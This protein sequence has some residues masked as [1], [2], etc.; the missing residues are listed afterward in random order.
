[1]TH[2]ERARTEDHPSAQPANRDVAAALLCAVVG[3]VLAVEPHLAILARHG[4][5]ADFGD[6]DDVLYTTLA[7]GPYRS[8]WA[9]GDPF[10]PAWAPQPTL[11]SWLPFVPLAKLTAVLGIDRL[12]MP[13]VWRALGGPMLGLAV[14]IVFRRLL[15][16]TRRPVSWALGCA[17]VSLA[18]SGFVGGQTLYGA[19]GL[20]RAIGR[21]DTPMSV[22][23]ALG[24][25]RVVTPLLNLPVLL[26]LAALLI[27]PMNR[28]RR[29]GAA[30]VGAALLGLCVSL[31]FYFW[32]AAAL[33]LVIVLLGWIVVGGHADGEPQRPELAALARRERN[34]VGIVLVGGMVLGAPQ[35]LGNARTFADPA[36]K[37][38]LQRLNRG[39]ILF[40]SDPARTRYLAN[41]W[42]FAK[43]GLGALVIVGLRAWRLAVV[44]AFTASGYLLANSALV[45]G[46]E[47]ENFH[48]SYVHAPFG[49]VLALGALAVVLDRLRWD[50]RW[51]WALPAAVVALGMFWRSYEATHCRE[52]VLYNQTLRDLL[53]LRPALARLGPDD[54]LAGPWQAGVAVMLGDSG[55][56]YQYDQT[57]VTSFISTRDAH[58]RKGLSA[59][60]RGLSLEESLDE[61]RLEESSHGRVDRWRRIFHEDLFAG[62]LVGPLLDRYRP[63]YLLRARADGPPKAERGG[64]WTLVETRGTWSLWRR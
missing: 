57:L 41:Y 40:P 52:S 64:P 12:L 19:V 31:Y 44:W 30:L 46:L 26:G 22:P 43:L 63:N 39:R 5:L 13:L 53:P 6:G 50:G 4:T 51:L 45:T 29:K 25:F 47:F 33:T 37:P 42:V 23:N 36:S 59:W 21:G 8:G 2:P 24:Q 61:L 27:P 32:T 18:D 60:L 34:L 10:S 9:L 55:L 11:Y 54:V 56:L 58:Q 16:T 38:I 62:V 3:L 49:E 20:V 7:R 35:I 14:Y 1:M 15:A 48:W 17:L 28:P